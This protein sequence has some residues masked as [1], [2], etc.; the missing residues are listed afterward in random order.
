MQYSSQ[1]ILDFAESWRLPVPSR[2]TFQDGFWIGLIQSQ[3]DLRKNRQK[4]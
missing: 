4:A 3:Q 2:Q 1:S